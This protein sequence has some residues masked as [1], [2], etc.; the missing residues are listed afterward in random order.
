[1]SKKIILVFAILI[2]YL[3]IIIISDF[4]KFSSNMLQFKIEYLGIVLALNFSVLIQK[5]YLILSY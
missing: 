2:F 3:G 5:Y 1:M 4:E